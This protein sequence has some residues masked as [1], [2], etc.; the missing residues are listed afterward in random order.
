MPSPV[1]PPTASSMVPPLM[2]ILVLPVAIEPLPMPAP[3]SPPLA[4]TVPPLMVILVLVLPVALE[5]LPMP[6][7]PSLPL[8]P[9]ISMMPAPLFL[10]PPM[11]AA[12]LPPVA[13]R[14]PESF[15]DVMVSLPV[16]TESSLS[17]LLF[18]L[19]S[20]PACPSPLVRVLSPLSV[21]VVSPAPSTLRAALPLAGFV[22]SRASMLTSSSV[23]LRVLALRLLMIRMTLLVKFLTAFSTIWVELFWV[24][25]SSLAL[26]TLM[27]AP[28]YVSWLLN[29]G[30]SLDWVFF[31]KSVSF[32][33]P[34]EVP[35]VWFS[36][37]SPPVVSLGWFLF[38]SPPVVP[39][40]WFSFS[41]PPVVSPVWFSF[42]SLP[43]VLLG[44]FLFSSPPPLVSPR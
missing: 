44:W 34:P 12:P 16:S 7:P 18:S 30:L 37:S 2:V 21:I 40:G 25:S 42:S 23:T 24:S 38:S 31:V 11:P 8:P 14:M 5:P 13:V 29:T 1:L 33:S 15:S 35:P 6:A 27:G 20:R 41:S 22:S 32:F 17:S 36:F 43:V 39:L 10:A 3:L 26:A 19:C 28:V 9:A 4:F